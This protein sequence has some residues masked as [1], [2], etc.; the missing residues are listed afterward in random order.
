LFQFTHWRWVE[1]IRRRVSLVEQE[2]LTLPEHLSSPPV[3][4]GVHVFRALVLCV[5]DSWHVWDHRG[6][7][8]MVVGF[9][10]TYSISAYYDLSC[11]F[12]SHSWQGVLET[13]LCNKHKGYDDIVPFSKT[14]LDCSVSAKHED[15]AIHEGHAYLLWLKFTVPKYIYQN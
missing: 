15:F 8:Y 11:Q 1:S 13:T 5:K 12:E 14:L 3:L 9:L 7:D 10:T 4:N 2:L 6:H